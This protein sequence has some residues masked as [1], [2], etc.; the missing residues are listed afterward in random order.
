L[1]NLQQGQYPAGKEAMEK[2]ERTLP[3]PEHA[4]NDPSTNAGATVE[5]L[6]AR[7]GQTMKAEG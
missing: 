4:A 1:V 6:R 5:Q 7:L 3:I 2:A